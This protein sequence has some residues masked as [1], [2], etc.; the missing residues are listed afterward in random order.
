MANLIIDIGN[1]AV[2]AA[3]SEGITLG[4]TYR[5]QGEKTIDFVLAIAKEE[6][7]LVM[8]ISSVYEISPSDEELLK[9]VCTYLLIL[10]GRHPSILEERG[11]PSYITYDRAASII[12]ARHLFE[13]KGCTVFDFGTTMTVDFIDEEGKYR[14]GNIALGLRARFKALNRYSRA[15]PLVDT[16]SESPV[17][18][19][20]FDTSVSAGVIT[21]IEF[22]ISGYAATKPGNMI[23]FTGGDAIY[24][25]KRTKKSIFVVCNLVLIGL[26]II[27]DEYVKKN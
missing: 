19:D 11:L 10:D 8:A 21:G 4:K 5:Y 20:T 12:A 14:G 27:A 22:E 9:G 16:P 25:A 18:G 2:K 7:P 15:L 26:A 24:F 1:T 17:I 6:K 13:G 3:R 23:I